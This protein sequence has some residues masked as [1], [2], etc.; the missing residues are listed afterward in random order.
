MVGVISPDSLNLIPHTEAIAIANKLYQCSAL[1]GAGDRDGEQDEEQDDEASESSSAEISDRTGPCGQWEWSTWSPCPGYCIKEGDVKNV[2]TRMKIYTGDQG[3]DECGTEKD[4]EECGNIPCPGDEKE[5]YSEWGQWTICSRECGEGE[6]HR[7]RDAE[8][9]RDSSGVECYDSQDYIYQSRPCYNRP[10]KV[11]CE[12]GEWTTWEKCS[13]DCGTGSTR[14][15]RQIATSPANGGEECQDLY[16]IKECQVQ[17]CP[18]P[19]TC[20][21][22]EWTEWSACSSEC[23]GGTSYRF[24]T[25]LRRPTDPIA[26]CPVT[27]DSRACNTQSCDA[28]DHE[29][30]DVVDC[31]VTT[32]APWSACSKT[33]GSGI[34]HR[35]RV[36]VRKPKNGGQPC[37]NLEE[38]KPCDA[39]FCYGSCG[40]TKWTEWSGCSKVCGEGS[41]SRYRYIRHADDIDICPSLTEIQPCFVQ[42]VCPKKPTKDKSFETTEEIDC[43]LSNWSVWTVCTV[44]C[45][46]GGTQQRFREMVMSPSGGGR[47]CRHLAEERFG[48]NEHITC[49]DQTGICEVSNWTAWS[50][51]SVTCGEGLQ[52]RSRSITQRTD[53]APCPTLEDER[54]CNKKSCAIIDEHKKCKMSQWSPWT[55]CDVECGTGIHIRTRYVKEGFTEEC[56]QKQQTKICKRKPCSND[57]SE[58]S[59]YESQ[60]IY[61]EQADLCMRMI[62]EKS[63]EILPIFVECDINDQ[64]QQ[65]IWT[66]NGK[67]YKLSNELCLDYH[68]ESTDVDKFD[69]KNFQ[70]STCSTTNSE[71]QCSGNRILVKNSFGTGC[72]SY[73]RVKKGNVDVTVVG[74]EKC[75]GTGRQTLVSYDSREPI[76][77][78]PSLLPTQS[79]EPEEG[80]VWIRGPIIECPDKN[81]LRGIQTIDDTLVGECCE[82]VTVSHRCEVQTVKRSGDNCVNGVVTGLTFINNQQRHVRCCER[83]HKLGKCFPNTDRAIQ[84]MRCNA[85]TVMKRLRVTCKAGCKAEMTCCNT[86]NIN[87]HGGTMVVP[88]DCIITQQ[89]SG[90][91]GTSNIVCPRSDSKIVMLQGGYIQ[92]DGKVGVCCEKRGQTLGYQMRDAGEGCEPNQVLTGLHFDASNTIKQLDCAEVNIAFKDCYTNKIA[93]NSRHIGC[94]IGEFVTDLSNTCEDPPCPYS[95]TCCKKD[96]E[97]SEEYTETVLPVGED[98]KVLNAVFYGS[99][100]LHYASCRRNNVEN[101]FINGLEIMSGD[102][103]YV[104]CKAP[105]SFSGCST[106][107]AEKLTLECSEGKVLSSVGLIG[108][109]FYSGQCCDFNKRSVVD[110]CIW[111]DGK[112]LS[113]PDDKAFTG[114]KTICGV[115]DCKIAVKCCQISRKKDVISRITDKI[116]DIIDD[117]SKTDIKSEDDEGCVIFSIVDLKQGDGDDEIECIGKY[118]MLRAYTEQGLQCC[119]TRYKTSFCRIQPIQKECPYGG[120]M[121][122]LRMN[123]DGVVKEMVCC[124]IDAERAYCELSESCSKAQIMGGIAEASGK[125]FDN[126]CY[127]TDKI[128][129]DCISKYADYP[130]G[131]ISMTLDLSSVKDC[132]RLCTDT[133]GCIAFVLSP[134]SRTCTLKDD[135]HQD[136]SYET[137][138]AVKGGIAGLVNCRDRD[139]ED[140]VD[141]FDENCIE[142]KI[143]YPGGDLRTSRKL[144]LVHCIEACFD[145]PR[146]LRVVYLKKDLTCTLKRKGWEKRT[147]WSEN[148]ISGSLS[149]SMACAQESLEEP[150]IE[151]PE[152]FNEDL[153]GSH[154]AFKRIW[155]TQAV[156]LR[157]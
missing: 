20:D 58:R 48:C 122:G 44:S 131:F 129:G 7:T 59:E 65:W 50:E 26:K 140:A 119:K 45:G 137:S 52:L 86:D 78:N 114:V 143:D 9:E 42:E 21:L 11:D 120:I 138:T 28:A 15:L 22:S 4:P 150:P 110:E 57:K 142:T 103:R 19:R 94:P 83:D 104:C 92:V 8:K 37:G 100:R 141:G 154:T 34:M 108:K 75:G 118:N 93:P 68:P 117:Y 54:Y 72:L 105:K 6:E 125:M 10:C 41:R 82:D 135:T 123:E 77:Y 63:G 24:R 2:R 87:G 3:K 39:G 61:S 47:Q 40:L 49:K 136:I 85:N 13:K 132:S 33:C 5:C 69:H 23:D 76:C 56:P 17:E 99:K 112:T 32:W 16:E 46:V 67:L 113:C 36:I 97:M 157:K 62:T 102:I 133:K 53:D 66:E 64:E 98:C 81:L 147:K 127:L 124:E 55:A 30:P 126:C 38:N 89:Q 145:T 106:I 27:E 95:A 146:C 84:P 121:T 70:Y 111:Y 12:V 144:S 25:I 1:A 43:E 153:K 130:G 128:E 109:N 149:V 29:E 152:E 139:R 73:L 60:M 18:D 88:N 90:R 80:C 35:F 155:I 156:L 96:K 74:I 115:K 107:K 51:C 91:K 148:A 116:D 14:R 134:V 79:P 151:S 31:E 101:N 71:F